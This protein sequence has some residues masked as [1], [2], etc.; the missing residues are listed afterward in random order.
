M[1]YHNNRIAGWILLT[2]TMINNYYNYV[3]LMAVV[4][5]DTHPCL[6]KQVRHF[7]VPQV[8][9]RLCEAKPEAKNPIYISVGE[10]Y[11]YD[12]A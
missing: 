2:I 10:M 9:G 7:R 11:Q 1:N 4:L 3:L 6:G 5:V 8:S 12:K